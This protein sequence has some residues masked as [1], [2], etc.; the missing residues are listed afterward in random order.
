MYMVFDT[1][2]REIQDVGDSNYMSAQFAWNYSDQ[3]MTQL[4]SRVPPDS[5]SS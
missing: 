3:S 5:G 2:T 4:D 1:D